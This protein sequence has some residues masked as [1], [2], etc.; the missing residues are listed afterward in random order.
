M[1]PGDIGIMLDMSPWAGHKNHFRRIFLLRL[2]RTLWTKQTIM[3]ITRLT[4]IAE[5]VQGQIL[6]LLYIVFRI[7]A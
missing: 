6:Q 3:R 1:E 5:Q 7:F 4:L 2:G